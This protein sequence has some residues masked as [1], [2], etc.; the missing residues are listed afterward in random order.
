MIVVAG[1]LGGG[2]WGAL[3]ARRRKGSRLDMAQYAVGYG[4]LFALIGLFVTI[5]LARLA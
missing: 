3:Q 5:A 2:V 1:F 4:T